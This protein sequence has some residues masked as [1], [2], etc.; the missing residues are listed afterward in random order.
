ME[1]LCIIPAR[2]GSK[3]IPMKNIK[4]FCGKPLITY[5]ISIALSCASIKR[6]IVSS[7]S[8]NIIEVATEYGAETPF[9]RP[10]ELA[11]DDT[12]DL[13]VFIHCL[14]YLKINEGYIPDIIVQLRPTSPIRT[15]EMIEKGIKM[16]INN[17]EADSVRAVCEPSQNPYKMWKKQDDG[18]LRPLIEIGIKESYN[19][20]RQNLPDVYWQNGYIDI[21]RTTTIINKKSMTGDKVLPLILGS[22]HTIDIDNDFTFRLAEMMQSSLKKM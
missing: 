11:E 10:N 6:V 15:V 8:K 22:E 17:P 1:I 9:I 7:D 3:S 5:S 16:L 13:P 20:P 2:G 12:T 19:S 18:Y 4:L 14:E 21:I